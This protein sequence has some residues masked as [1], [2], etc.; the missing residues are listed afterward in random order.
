MPS[1]KRMNCEIGTA[2]ALQKSHWKAPGT[3]VGML[4]NWRQS[5]TSGKARRRNANALRNGR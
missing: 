1:N 4:E 3:R 5:A 2:T